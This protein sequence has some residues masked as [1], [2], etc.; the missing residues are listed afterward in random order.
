MWETGH[1]TPID[2]HSQDSQKNHEEVISTYRNHLLN[3]AQV[4]MGG[5]REQ[6]SWAE[7]SAFG[8]PSLTCT[9][10]SFLRRLEFRCSGAR[11]LDL[12]R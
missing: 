11:S 4:S 9:Y 7:G 8:V 6:E 2:A 5:G 10:S 3:A 1:E 12:M